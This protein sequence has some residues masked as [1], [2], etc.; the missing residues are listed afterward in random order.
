M[1]RL[2]WLLVIAAFDDLREGA[3]AEH[4]HDLKSVPKMLS[5]LYLVVA[6]EVVEARVALELSVVEVLCL[7]LLL[8]ED[9]F[10]FFIESNQLL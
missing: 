4:L 2:I 3:L 9:S 6:F 10:L 1:Q 7:T 8:L 5:D